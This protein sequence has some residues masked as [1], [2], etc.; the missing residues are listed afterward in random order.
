MINVVEKYVT[1]DN[2]YFDTEAE[3]EAYIVDRACSELNEKFKKME[4]Y[5]L[6]HRD[7]CTIISGLYGSYERLVETRDFL[8][9]LL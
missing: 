3:A 8:I 7:L 6:K 2:T 4:T 9:K 5:D 1:N